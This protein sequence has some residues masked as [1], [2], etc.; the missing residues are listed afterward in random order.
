MKLLH[1]VKSKL[2]KIIFFILKV[3]LP[4]VIILFSNYSIEPQRALFTFVSSVF[5]IN[6][7][8]SLTALSILSSMKVTKELYQIKKKTSKIFDNLLEELLHK[9][10]INIYLSLWIMGIC[11]IY[12][13]S[14]ECLISKYV[15][16]LLCAVVTLFAIYGIENFISLFRYLIKVLIKNAYLESYKSDSSNRL[17]QNHFDKTSKFKEVKTDENNNLMDIL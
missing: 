1:Y 9:F 13:I 8:F 11:F 14:I 5:S 2:E 12:Y 16:T 3:S 4:L 15:I 17:K 10:K 6:I 7:G